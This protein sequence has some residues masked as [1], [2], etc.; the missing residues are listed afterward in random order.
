MYQRPSSSSSTEST[1]V[2]DLSVT[3]MKVIGVGGAGCNAINRMINEGIRNV[4][5]IA[6]NTDI[7]A[8]NKNLAPNKLDIGSRL[9]RGLGAGAK[10]EIG[11]KAAQEDIEEIRALLEGADMV[12]ITAGMGG[13][14]GTGAAPIFAQVA[15]EVGALTVAVVTL[16]FD[17]E[18]RKRHDVALQGIERLK[19]HVDTMLVISNSRIFKVIERRAGV[20]DAFNKIDEV[21]KQAVQGISS[22]ISETGEINVDFADVKTVLS[23]KGEAI[24]GIGIAHGESRAVEAAKMALENPLIEN[25]SFTNSGAMLVN[26]IGGSD[27]AMH[28]YEEAASTISDYCREDAEIIIGL[29]IDENLKDKVRIII[30]ATDFV[31]GRS[32]APEDDLIPAED[33]FEPRKVI[34]LNEK[35][36]LKG[37]FRTYHSEQGS[38][39]VRKES[40]SED[41][42]RDI[43]AFIRKRRMG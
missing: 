13:G 7:Q 22:I 23:N 12:F 39:F 37:K 5:F 29:R 2:S 15:K 32:L 36:S 25:T 38:G 31:Q 42:D 26:I 33:I 3:T 20:K 14:T 17:F 19:E 41:V 4:D 10:P 43:P 40:H 24:M 6:V 27:F 9:T 30:V 28:E 8:L 35:P 21:L 1:A 16:P 11:E 34:Q 18:G